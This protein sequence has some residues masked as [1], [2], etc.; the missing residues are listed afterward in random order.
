MR[1]LYVPMNIN[2]PPGEWLHAYVYSVSAT[3]GGSAASFTKFGPPTYSYAGAADGFG[4][5]TNVTNAPVFP[6]QGV[7]SA[8]STA[9]PAG[10]ALSQITQTGTAVAHGGMYF[11]IDG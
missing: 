8:T 1:E 5:N 3:N 11:E 7:F 9:F 6:G 4:A 2:M 10:I